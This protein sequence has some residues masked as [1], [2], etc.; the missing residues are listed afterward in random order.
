MECID[1]ERLTL[2]DIQPSQFYISKGKIKKISLW[3][4]KNNME[5]FHL[6]PIKILDGI[7][8]MIDGYTRAVYSIKQDLRKVPF[9]WDEDELNFLSTT[10]NKA[11]FVYSW[12]I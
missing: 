3:F 1:L 12:E 2:K 10:M 8:V 11:T 6:I 5:N 4:Y 9:V 7:P